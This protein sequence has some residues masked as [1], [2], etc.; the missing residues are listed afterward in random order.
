MKSRG[1]RPIKRMKVTQEIDNARERKKRELEETIPDYAIDG[2]VCCCD[3]EVDGKKWSESD[4]FEVVKKGV[5][6]SLRVQR[7]VRIFSIRLKCCRIARSVV[8]IYVGHNCFVSYHH[9]TNKIA[10][11]CREFVNFKK[12]QKPNFMCFVKSDSV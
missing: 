10:I 4:D 5:L 12:S 7:E 8:F 1:K 11:D 6:E 9:R 3:V 2:C